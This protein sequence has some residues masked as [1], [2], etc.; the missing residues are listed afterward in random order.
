[1]V[2]ELSGWADELCPRRRIRKAGREKLLKQLGH[3]QGVFAH[4]AKAPVLMRAAQSEFFDF[5]V[6]VGSDI[7][8]RIPKFFPAFFWAEKG[9]FS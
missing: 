4:R 7:Q 6:A 8:R 3:R 9:G 5:N 1:M 2:M